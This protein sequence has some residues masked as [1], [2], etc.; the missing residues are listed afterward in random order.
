MKI[1][2]MGGTFDPIHNGHLMLG[3]AALEQFDLD[4]VWFMP[5]GN[6]PHKENA[7]IGSSV[8]D[9][10]AMTAL[11][12]EGIK[13]FRLELYEAEKKGVSYSYA[14]LEHFNE[15][16]KADEFYFIVGAD[17]LFM[18]ES[19]VKPERIF[20]VC[21]LLAACRGEISTPEK[22]RE[23]ISCLEKKYNARIEILKAP[24]MQVSSHG[25]R[26][27]IKAGKSFSAYVPEKVAEYIKKEGLY[28]A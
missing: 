11:A 15:L 22:M 19:W 16:K 12:I 28:G 27:R 13:E 3:K 2:I 4:E 18:I 9:R 20:P 5:N 8:R 23:Q 1:G 24:L 17:S 6:P 14:T 10:C 26:E 7:S 25:L 21:R